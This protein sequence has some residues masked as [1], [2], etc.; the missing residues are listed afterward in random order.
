[1]FY[2]NWG[3]GR[4]DG[5]M[6]HAKGRAFGQPPTDRGLDGRDM[7]AFPRVAGSLG[8]LRRRRSGFD[9]VIPV[10]LKFVPFDVHHGEGRLRH[11]A[12][13]FIRPVIENCLDG[14]AGRSRGVGGCTE[15]RCR[16]SLAGECAR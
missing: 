6:E 13:G 9:D 10:S 2:A 11:L 8:A 16:S 12:P 3:K 14:Q 15:P 1:M 4:N 7:G 5:A